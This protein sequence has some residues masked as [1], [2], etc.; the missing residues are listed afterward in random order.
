MQGNKVNKAMGKVNIKNG[1]GYWM[2]T[3]IITL[4]IQKYHKLKIY[5]H[6]TTGTKRNKKNYWCNVYCPWIG[7]RINLYK[8]LTI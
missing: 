2:F 7:A 6:S 8:M 4:K 5:N 3:T 1:K